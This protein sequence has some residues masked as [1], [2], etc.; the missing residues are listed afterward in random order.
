MHARN[1]RET[2]LQSQQC[3]QHFGIAGSSQS[4]L[5][6]NYHADLFFLPIS[7]KSERQIILEL[8][9]LDKKND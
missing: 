6:T 4:L 2:V 5:K 8:Y 3:Y 7:I 1:K 9:L